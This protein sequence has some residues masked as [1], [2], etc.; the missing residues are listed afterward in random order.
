MRTFK[1]IPAL[2]LAVG[3]FLLVQF[4]SGQN[5]CESPPCAPNTVPCV[6]NTGIWLDDTFMIDYDVES[7]EPELISQGIYETSVSGTA[8]EVCPEG[9]GHTIEWSILGT[10]AQEF[11]VP[12][13]SSGTT[14]LEWAMTHGSNNCTGGY[15]YDDDVTWIFEGEMPNNSCDHAS[16]KWYWNG[17]TPEQGEDMSISKT[18]ADFPSG[19]PTETTTAVGWSAVQPTM[20]LFKGTIAPA[21]AS[22]GGRQVFEPP[23]SADFDNCHFFLSAFDPWTMQGGGWFVDFEGE[24][25]NDRV[26]YFWDVVDY[27]RDEGEYPCGAQGT[28]PMKLYENYISQ[29]NFSASA[30]YKQNV[31][32]PLIGLITVAVERDG[33][34]TWRNWG[35][36]TDT[37]SQ[38][39]ARVGSVF[40]WPLE[41]EMAGTLSS[42]ILLPGGGDLPPGLTISQETGVISG[43]PSGLGGGPYIFRVRV[44]DSLGFYATRI[45]AI[46]VLPPLTLPGGQTV[47]D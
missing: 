21:P 33:V 19:T 3:F 34:N 30:V 38:P 29:N 4:V 35:I 14:A 1:P 23:T 36:M 22:F 32:E 17:Q 20:A 42:W 43:V 16:G 27:Y 37:L 10:I 15:P 6:H 18:A 47:G 24:Y 8:T 12:N 40:A 5:A 26:G 39:T 41:A 25:G 9:E 13:T 7:E 28:Q 46:T 31:L 2:L 45:Y 11:G 44:T